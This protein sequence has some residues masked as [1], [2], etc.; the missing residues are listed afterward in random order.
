MPRFFWSVSFQS[1]DPQKRKEHSLC[2]LLQCTHTHI[3]TFCSIFYSYLLNDA[4]DF[5][6]GEAVSTSHKMAM[7]LPCVPS[8][9]TCLAA[10]YRFVDSFVI[11]F[12]RWGNILWKK[13]NLFRNGS[14]VCDL[15]EVLCD[16]SE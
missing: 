2:I 15:V 4:K 16:E 12:G 6:V 7:T 10:F 3:R 5:W 13:E 9:S 8:V 14:S 1:I 11:S